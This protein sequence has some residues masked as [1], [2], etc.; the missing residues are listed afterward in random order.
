MPQSTS[1]TAFILP[2]PDAKLKAHSDQLTRKILA[3]I[4]TE[5]PISFHDYMEMALY[6]P[7]L[8]Y[9]SAGMTKLGPHGDF[10]TAPELG[11]LFAR[12]LA[13]TIS[14]AAGILGSYSIMEVGAGS[15]ALAGDLLDAL[16]G[17]P[18]AKYLVLERS[19][20][21]IERQRDLITL[22]HPELSARVE[23]L[24]EPPAD[25]CGIIIG[26]EIVDALPVER[27][28][29]S[30]GVIHQLMIGALDGRLAQMT[31]PAPAELS[32]Q[33][34]RVIPGKHAKLAGPYESEINTYLPAW[35]AGLTSGLTR[36]LVILSDYGYPRGEYYYEQRN[37]GTLLCH[38]RHRA[39]DD[40][41]FWPGLQDI[42]AS[43]DFTALAEAGEAADLDLLAYTSQAGFMIAA[44]LMDVM[45]DPELLDERG[46]IAQANQVKQ[47]TLPSEMGERFQFML[48][49]RNM[50]AD[51]P[52]MAGPDFCYR[53]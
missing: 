13:Q 19:A 10:I 40:A 2:Q 48:M 15:G 32:R 7:G 47:L 52:G 39:H 8:G 24:V 17:N 45:T 25:F 1:K 6:E 27:F 31:R 30:E 51:L 53:L 29:I 33:V 46:R 35:L 3:R 38:Y 50:P 26:N 20:D 36:G 12:C 23:W 4:R 22:R 14:A 5:G 49:G 44:G 42:T 37:R 21:L 34:A 9:Y 43:V 16:S 28:T 18:P 11:P 41:L